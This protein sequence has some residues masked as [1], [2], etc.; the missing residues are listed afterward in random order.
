MD[1]P[2]GLEPLIK[3]IAAEEV[4]L[5]EEANEAAAVAVHAAEVAQVAAENA[6]LSDEAAE[7]AAGDALDAAAITEEEVQAWPETP[8]E[9]RISEDDWK[10]IVERTERQ[11]EILL[12]LLRQTEPPEPPETPMTEAVEETATVDVEA[13]PAT[14]PEPP[15]T[16]SRKK[17]WLRKIL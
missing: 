4:A 11:D 9:F 6:A 2:T 13:P 3:Q 15:A 10:R 1:E 5:V 12:E 7:Q 16:P 14:T 8:S 17:S